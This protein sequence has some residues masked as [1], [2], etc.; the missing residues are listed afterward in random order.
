MTDPDLID[1]L[2]SWW[3]LVGDDLY[4]CESPGGPSGD[5]TGTEIAEYWGP[6]R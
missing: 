3:R 5:W 6:V 4:R 1:A 2:G